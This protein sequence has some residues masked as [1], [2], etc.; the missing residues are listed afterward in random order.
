MNG[1]AEQVFD[2]PTAVSFG[3]YVA[4]MRE[5]AQRSKDSAEEIARKQE[6]SHGFDRHY[7][8]QQELRA[9]Q[10]KYGSC[11]YAALTLRYWNRLLLR[12]PCHLLRSLRF[13]VTGK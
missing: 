2:D 1:A 8:V 13:I 6:G 9:F 7:F 4:I 3:T 10:C 5:F 11:S 12:A